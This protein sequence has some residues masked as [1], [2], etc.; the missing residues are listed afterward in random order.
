MMK[1]YWLGIE[2]DPSKI[3]EYLH[4]DE[5]PDSYIIVDAQVVEQC[6]ECETYRTNKKL[7]PTCGGLG[8][9]ERIALVGIE[10]GHYEDIKTVYRDQQRLMKR[11]GDPA[12]NDIRDWWLA[13]GKAE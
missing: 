4:E 9:I 1:A 5:L 11:Y 3:L 8:E 10:E 12:P 13:S 6:L 7:C 2:L